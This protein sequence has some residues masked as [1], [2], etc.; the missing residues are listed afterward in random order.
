MDAVKSIRIPSDL[1][2]VIG[3]RA[4]RERVDDSTAMRQ[5]MALG[6]TEYAVQLYREGHL[7]LNQAAKM[8]GTSVREMLEVLW[9]HGVRGNVTAEQ[10]RKGVENIR[11]LMRGKGS[12][13][14]PR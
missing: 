9:S 14:T 13:A 5:L 12:G 4:R 3:E 8:A 10:T 1:L 6:A 7:T 11:E 2:S